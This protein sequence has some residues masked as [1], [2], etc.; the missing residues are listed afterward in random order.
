M[1]QR[2]P[3]IGEDAIRDYP[4]PTIPTH[5]LDEEPK[6]TRGERLDMMPREPRCRICR[7][8]SVRVQ[9]NAM[10]DWRGVRIRFGRGKTRV[11]TYASILRDLEPLNKGRDAADR[12]TYDSLWMHAK[13]HYDIKGIS[14]YWNARIYKEL[15]IGLR[16]RRCMG[17][18]EQT[19]SN[20]TQLAI[21]TKDSTAGPAL[22]LW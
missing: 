21:S 6:K 18:V 8:E 7:R 20:C 9:V 3:V 11:V 1:L 13:H 4:A 17:P 19:Q 5:V 16:G 15:R 12:I 10:L 2:H 22:A 14:D